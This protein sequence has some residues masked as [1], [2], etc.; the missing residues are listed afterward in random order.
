[1]KTLLVVLLMVAITTIGLQATVWYVHPDSSLDSI[2][3]ALDEYDLEDNDIILVG[4]GTYYES[5]IEWP[6]KSGIKLMSQYGP[7]STVIW[8]NEE[9]GSIILKLVGAKCD[10]ATRV[11]GFTFKNSFVGVNAYNN[12]KFLLDNCVFEGLVGAISISNHSSPTVKNC[13]IVNGNTAISMG[14]SSS[15]LIEWCTITNN[16][17]TNGLGVI[18][19]STECSPVIHYCDIFGNNPDSGYAVENQFAIPTTDARFN[20]WGS[21]DGPSGYGPGSG[22]AVSDYVD[23]TPWFSSPNS[24]TEEKPDTEYNPS[25]SSISVSPNPFH[26]RVCIKYCMG[27]SNKVMKLKIYD[28]TGRLVQTLINPNVWDGRD[29]L[30]R[31]TP[32]GIYFLRADKANVGKL[33]KVK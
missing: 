14:S 27:Q 12:T 8:G 2:G 7:D 16:V 11:S 9:Y 21:T 23:Y 30:G 18:F 22:D 4:P 26:E 3:E 28:I 20:Y 1:M 17:T 10:T 19:A 13:H 29:D 32:P 33:V 5:E 25:L 31:E 15:P 6:Y 24:I